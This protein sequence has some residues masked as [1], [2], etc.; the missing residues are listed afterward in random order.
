MDIKHR[1]CYNSLLIASFNSVGLSS[2]QQKEML[3]FI[4]E[5]AYNMFEH[6]KESKLRRIKRQFLEKFY[7]EYTKDYIF[8][9]SLDDALSVLSR[10]NIFVES[11]YDGEYKFVYKYLYFFLVAQAMSRKLFTESVKQDIEEMCTTAYLEDSANILL[12]L[13]YHSGDEELI[14]NLIFTSMVPFEPY[15]EITLKKDDPIFLSL[16]A[17]IGKI[18]EK[19]IDAD[20]RPEEER[21]HELEIRDKHEKEVVTEES[22]SQ[23]YDEIANH[24][25]LRDLNQAIRSIRILGQ[26]VKNQRSD[27]KKSLI[28]DLLKESYK[29]CFRVISF[30]GNYLAEN[31][32][33]FIEYLEEQRAKGIERINRNLLKL[34]LMR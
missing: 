13:V 31:E 20:K 32:S 5:L 30:Y 1:Y 26:I 4:S 15:D 24:P 19:I 7:N 9:Y 33:D 29:T 21:M 23:I 6:R 27:I 12:F 16:N 8:T 17:L 18:E 3:K 14:E 2:D 34:L 25:V 28:V 11:E 22:S 10:A